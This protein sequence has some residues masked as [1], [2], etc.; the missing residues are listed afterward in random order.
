[1][2]KCRGV[3]P[4]HEQL[5][6]E[7]SALYNALKAKARAVEDAEDAAVEAMADVDTTE[8]ALEDAIRD[9]DAEAAKLDRADRSRNVQKSIFPNGYGEMIDPEG[10]GQ[11]TVMPK[12]HVRI[13]PF[14]AL[15][16]MP[17]VIARLNQAEEAFRQAL[18]AEETASGTVETL[19]AEENEARRA[20]REQIES[21]YGR[22]RDFYKSRPALA[23]QFFL[24]EGWRRKSKRE[25]G[26]GGSTPG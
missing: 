26:S 19:F 5:R 10:E 12:L 7:M 20:I 2:G 13:A 1:M 21:A 3:G 25:P 23:E 9:I 14:A 24:N 15:P 17:E 16:G 22:L 6:S 4:L 8:I 18:K 11:L